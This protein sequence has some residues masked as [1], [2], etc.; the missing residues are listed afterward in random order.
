MKL[1]I[2]CLL[3]NQLVSFVHME[4]GMQGEWWR[5]KFLSWL[6]SVI[7]HI[8]WFFLTNSRAAAFPLCSW[9]QSCQC[10]KSRGSHGMSKVVSLCPEQ[11]GIEDDPRFVQQPGES[12]H[13]LLP[14]LYLTGWQ[15]WH[16]GEAVFSLDAVLLE[17]LLWF[18]PTQDYLVVCWSHCHH[19]KVHIF[20]CRATGGVFQITTVKSKLIQYLACLQQSVGFGDEQWSGGMEK[21]GFMLVTSPVHQC[22]GTEILFRALWF[23]QC[24]SSPAS[25]CLALI[26]YHLN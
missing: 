15:E 4:G 11:A 25:S 20:P 14:W 6:I 10:T 2:W 16:R 13:Q 7:V 24:M 12:C 19:L 18:G 8:I 1:I 5:E 3:E 9:K 17:F 26:W 21:W 23:L 22:L